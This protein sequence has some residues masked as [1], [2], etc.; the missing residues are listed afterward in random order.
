MGIKAR[1][2]DPSDDAWQEYWRLYCLQR[3]AVTDG[4]KLFESEFASLISRPGC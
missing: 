2:L 3:L 1:R 4:G